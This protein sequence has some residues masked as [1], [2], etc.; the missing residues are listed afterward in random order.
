MAY[1][2]ADVLELREVDRP[3]IGDD[4]VLV[5]VRAAGLDR[6]RGLIAKERAEDLD[7][8]TQLIESGAV[9]P[10][11]RPHIPP[12]RGARRDPLRRRWPRRREGRH[13]HIRARPN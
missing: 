7:A 9:T 12:G 6:L 11:H 8:L 1:G 2:S 3:S 5:Q 4:E 10:G 13:H